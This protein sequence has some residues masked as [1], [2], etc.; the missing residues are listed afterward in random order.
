[1]NNC[2]CII[3]ALDGKGGLYLGDVVSARNLEYLKN[4]NIRALVSLIGDQKYPSDTLDDHWH[5][6]IEDSPGSDLK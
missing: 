4:N 3:D 5:I 1:M 6:F 2:D